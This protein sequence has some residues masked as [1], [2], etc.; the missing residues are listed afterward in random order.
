[1]LIPWK[2][3]CFQLLVFASQVEDESPV[4]PKGIEPIEEKTTLSK[5]FL[6]KDRETNVVLRSLGF[7]F[8]SLYRI[9]S[10]KIAESTMCQAKEKPLYGPEGSSEGK[11]DPNTHKVP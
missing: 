2:R 5:G 6:E 10:R 4:K 11:V 1:M 9:F 3:F 7:G 8:G